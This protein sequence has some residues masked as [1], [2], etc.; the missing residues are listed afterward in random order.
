MSLLDSLSLLLTH[1]VRSATKYDT[2][3]AGMQVQTAETKLQLTAKAAE[4]KRKHKAIEKKCNAEE[5]KS[6]SKG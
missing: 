1:G 5:P 2:D 6:T 3:M 4:Y